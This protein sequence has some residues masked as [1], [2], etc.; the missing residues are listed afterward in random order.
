M[1]VTSA[2]YPLNISYA[3]RIARTNPAP[4]DRA[5]AQAAVDRVTISAEGHAMN[6]AVAEAVYRGEPPK[7]LRPGELPEIPSWWMNYDEAR[8]RAEDGVKEAMRQLGI[9]A[10]TQFKITLGSTD[11]VLGVEGNF[12]KKAEFEA[13]INNNPALRNALAA[14]DGAAHFQRI[15]AAGEKVRAAV[16]ADPSRFEELYTWLIS[17][18]RQISAMPF[19]FSYADG[20]L[21]GALIDGNGQRIG[22]LE[23]PETPPA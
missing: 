7:P 18:S 4:E 20:K 3:E 8:S 23:H 16:D 17:A 9:P 22:I 19:E 15:A 13:L 10:S 6:D 14:A 1:N 2:S 21:E 11:G 5:K 12:P